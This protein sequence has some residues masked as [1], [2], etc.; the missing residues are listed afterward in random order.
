VDADGFTAIAQRDRTALE[1]VDPMVSAS[2]LARRPLEGHP[3]RS[4]YVPFGEN[5]SYF[6]DQIFDAMTLAYGHPRAGD[7]VWAS[8]G[9]AQ[10]LV[11]LDAV[12]SYPIEGNLRSE[13]G[14]PY[15]GAAVQYAAPDFDGHGIYRRLE[16][17]RH[18]F[19]CFHAS[20]RKTGSARIV[21]PGA[22][23]G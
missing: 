16:A 1:A 22:P 4:I 8:M 17:V 9:Q 23:C 19:G 13:T 10:A 20:Y 6:P 5:D 15:T 2:R 11:G 14:A 3:T 12:A 7:E 21:A 18:Q